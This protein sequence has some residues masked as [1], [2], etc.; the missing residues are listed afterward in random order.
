M[1]QLDM[2]IVTQLPWLPAQWKTGGAQVSMP[3]SK[4]SPNRNVCM[5]RMRAR[6][7]GQDEG[8]WFGGRY[9]YAVFAPCYPPC[10]C[11]GLTMAWRSPEC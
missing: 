10:V 5:C 6:S 9:I 1:C 3:V 4:L 11:D 2:C 7:R 8:L